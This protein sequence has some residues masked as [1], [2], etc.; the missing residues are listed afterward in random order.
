MAATPITLTIDRDDIAPADFG[1]AV[2]EFVLLLRD[3][4]IDLSPGPQPTLQWRLTQLSYNSPLTVGM[5]CEPIEGAADI[6]PTVVSAAVRGIDQIDRT[7]ERPAEFS[8]DALDRLRRL[9]TFAADGLGP[10]R[11]NAPTV[12]LSSTVTKRTD[13]NLDTV[14]AQ[15]Y[16]LGSVEGVLE[17]LT[18]HGAPYFTVYDDVTGRGVR[19]YFPKSD[20]PNVLN[21]VEWKV[22][23]HGQLRRDALG[24]PNQIRPIEFFRRL[25]EHAAPVPATGLAGVYRGIGDTRSYLE[26]IRGE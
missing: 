22:L 14:L 5:E 9:A 20:L 1:E 13:A 8:D 19:C 2:R 3:I 11:V 17:G 12:N 21:S 24:R 7:A 6:G 4:D 26:L 23:V 10:M 18:V 15:G 16:Y 25:G